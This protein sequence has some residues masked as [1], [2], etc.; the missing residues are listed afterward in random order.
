MGGG[1]Q[2]LAPL[3]AAPFI[4]SFLGLLASRMP[5]GEG[6]VLGR[7]RCLSCG[8][9]LGLVDL[10]PLISYAALRGRCRHCD[11]PID[12]LC[13]LMELG[14]LGFA[15]WAVL[16]LPPALVWWGCLLAWT[17]LPL[18]VIDWRCL[19][20]PD[21]LT[22]FLGLGGVVFTVTVVPARWL[23]HGI[24]IIAGFTLCWLVAF[25]HRHGRGREGLGLGDAKLMAA[26]GAWV[27]WQGL[28]SCLFLAAV[29]ALF[30]I[31]VAAGLGRRI[32][33]DQAL[34]FGPALCLGLWLTWAQGPLLF[35]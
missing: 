26:A 22:L 6:V 3:V 10:V 8:T 18:A 9:V 16:V 5:K 7:S 12:P 28:G 11:E 20:L 1:W 31:L 35:G 30:G 32:A 13:L 19:R 27:G 17:L 33:A 21:A 25:A 4:G 15:A 24:G 14:A 29:I 23:D 2:A 34:P